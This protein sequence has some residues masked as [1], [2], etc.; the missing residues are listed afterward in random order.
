MKSSVWGILVSTSH[1]QGV[2]PLCSL[3]LTFSMQQPLHLQLLPLL[4]S[5]CL[6]HILRRRPC[7]LSAFLPVRFSARHTDT[8]LFARNSHFLFGVCITSLVLVPSS[9]QTPELLKNPERE[10]RIHIKH[11][12]E[13]VDGRG[14]QRVRPKSWLMTDTMTEI[15]SA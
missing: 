15:I 7:S 3:S 4:D 8:G 5:L 10:R 11:V 1:T 13:N 9:H 6:F 14:D 12:K 2:A